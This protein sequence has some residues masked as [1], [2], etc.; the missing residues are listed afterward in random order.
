MVVERA[1]GPLAV[2]GLPRRW[3][4]AAKERVWP[5][6][7]QPVEDHEARARRLALNRMHYHLGRGRRARDAGRFE[8]GVAEA[9]K[10]LLVN[11]QSGWALALLGQCL[12]HQP[13]PDLSCARRALER[14]QALDPTNGYFVRLLLDVLDAEGDQQ[15][16]ADVLAWAWWHGAPV[17]RWLPDGPPVR[18]PGAADLGADVPLAVLG[19]VDGAATPDRA[20][21]MSGRSERGP[22]LAGR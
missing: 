19:S 14:A 5:A 13:Q 8:E 1:A 4:L 15:A 10:A 21:E 20:D 9:R 11:P 18:Q 2:L 6:S 22:V 7:A 17:D 3:Y 16:R 12:M